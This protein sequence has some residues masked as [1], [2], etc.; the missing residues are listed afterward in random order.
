MSA[1]LALVSVGLALAVIAVAGDVIRIEQPPLRVGAR[2]SD[3]CLDNITAAVEQVVAAGVAIGEAVAQCPQSNHTAECVADISKCAADLTQAATF[4]DDAVTA[5][6]GH[7]NACVAD[8]LSI[9]HDLADASADV[10]KAVGNCAE[11]PDIAKCV[12][13]VIDVAGYVTKIVMGVEAAGSS[14]ARSV[15]ARARGQHRHVQL[16]LRRF[17]KLAGIIAGPQSSA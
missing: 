12:L 9:A 15:D 10:S 17:R 1:R 13:D 16:T 14:A 11:S 5:C 6:G 8:L 3:A 4:I 7:G 2:A